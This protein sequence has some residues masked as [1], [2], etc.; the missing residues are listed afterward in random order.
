MEVCFNDTIDRI[1][2]IITI[3]IIAKVIYVWGKK[4]PRST[5][6]YFCAKSYESREVKEVRIIKEFGRAWKLGKIV[7]IDRK[8]FWNIFHHYIL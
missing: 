6:L 7:N 4:I 5:A 2:T 8:D 3:D 1:D